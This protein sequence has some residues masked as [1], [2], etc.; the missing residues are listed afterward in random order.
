VPAATTASGT[1]FAIAA[2]ASSA[3]GVRSVISTTRNPAS[4]SVCARSMLRRASSI[5]TTGMT[6]ARRAKERRASVCGDIGP[7]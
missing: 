1:A 6:G 2:I 3:A 4:T 7:F 5:V